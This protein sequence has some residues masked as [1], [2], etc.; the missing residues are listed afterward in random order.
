VSDRIDG[1]D[2]AQGTGD[3]VSERNKFALKAKVCSNNSSPAE[4]PL[5]AR[6]TLKHILPL[7]GEDLNVE[8]NGGIEDRG[9]TILFEQSD[10]T[11]SKR[12][13]NLIAGWRSREIDIFGNGP[14]HKVTE[15]FG[16]EFGKPL[17][18]TGLIETD[19]FVHRLK[20]PSTST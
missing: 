11:L 3:L 20:N 10:V 14:P 8:V 6:G 9:R 12:V 1:D 18:Q 16:W 5:F 2:P 17:S 15:N 19:S 13:P 4:E 7:T